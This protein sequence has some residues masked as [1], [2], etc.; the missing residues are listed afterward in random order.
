[1]QLLKNNF[2]KIQA[3]GSRRVSLEIFTFS[4]QIMIHRQRIYI[5]SKNLILLIR[6]N[7]IFF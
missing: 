7:G 2:S 4:M 3:T 6:L 1:M 5:D